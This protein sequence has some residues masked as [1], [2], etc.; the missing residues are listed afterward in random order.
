M[1]YASAVK[2]NHLRWVSVNGSLKYKSCTSHDRGHE[3][4]H[5]RGMHSCQAS[6]Q[7]GFR[8]SQNSPSLQLCVTACD[9]WPVGRSRMQ[10]QLAAFCWG[11]A[12]CLDMYGAKGQHLPGETCSA[13]L[14]RQLGSAAPMTAGLAAAAAIPRRARPSPGPGA[15]TATGWL[16]TPHLQRQQTQ[17]QVWVWMSHVW[18][19]MSQTSWPRMS[20]KPRLWNRPVTDVC[21]R[22]CSPPP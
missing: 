4:K 12:L 1:L 7:R 18:V 21:G 2:D 17:G 22:T 5:Q 19:W 11:K 14:A 9:C 20:S 10:A 13:C 15:S 8:V 16:G 3:C 6:A